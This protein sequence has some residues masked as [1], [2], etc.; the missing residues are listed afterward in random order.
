MAAGPE[1]RSNGLT[2]PG[3]TLRVLARLESPFD[4]IAE[5]TAYLPL[6]V[7]LGNCRPLL[8]AGSVEPF[9]AATGR[10]GCVLMH[11][12]DIPWLGRD[13]VVRGAAFWGTKEYL[14][15]A[16]PDNPTD[17]PPFWW[18]GRP[19]NA[20]DYFEAFGRALAAERLR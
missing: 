11:W 5:W 7:V 1:F 6:E 2:I 10:T 19:A 13:I 12:R 4:L 17:S 14:R 8:A 9:R 15:Y 20:D 16:T 3:Y 18:M